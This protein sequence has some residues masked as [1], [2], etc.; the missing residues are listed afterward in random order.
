M[1]RERERERETDRQTDNRQTDRQTYQYIC[2]CNN[3][4]NHQQCLLC[5]KGHTICKILIK[6]IH[7]VSALAIDCTNTLGVCYL[8]LLCGCDL[9]FV[10]TNVMHESTGSHF[11]FQTASK[12]IKQL[13]VVV[14]LLCFVFVYF[15]CVCLFVVVVI[16][17]ILAI[18]LF[19]Y[20]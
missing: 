13:Y 9:N 16:F 4:G 15:V 6:F 7:S 14:F 11:L 8:I 18:Y 10:L 5:L 1:E 12:M 19:I 2:H 3:F 17:F 20:L